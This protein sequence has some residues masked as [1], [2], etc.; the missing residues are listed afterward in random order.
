[1]VSFKGAPVVKEIM[2]TCVRWYVAS[3]LSERQVEELLEA[4]GVSVDHATIHR[5]VLKYSPPLAEAFHRRKH[6]VGSS[7]CMDETDSR[8]NGAWRSVDRAVETPGQT[9]DLL[10]TAQRDQEA[11]RRVLKQAI[12][13]HGVPETI[14]IDGS[15]A[16]EAAITRYNKE[17]GTAN[18]VRTSFTSVRNEADRVGPT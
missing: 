3:P 2:L 14:T 15:E 8:V 18:H 7:W 17:H 4:R 11:A 6:P 10:L 12:C 1:M 9:M 16:N 5:W 13:R